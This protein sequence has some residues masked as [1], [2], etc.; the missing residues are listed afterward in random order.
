MALYL[1]LRYE[2]SIGLD[3]SEDNIPQGVYDT[4]ADQPWH[5]VGL[6]TSVVVTFDESKQFELKNRFDH[7]VS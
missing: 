4:L 7:G 1:F 5:D 6:D 2:W 3:W